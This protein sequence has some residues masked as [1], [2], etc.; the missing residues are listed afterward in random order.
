LGWE[1]PAADPLRFP[2]AAGA[3]GGRALA[4]RLRRGNVEGEYADPDYVVLMFTPENPEED[5]A[6]VLHA[7]RGGSETPVARPVPLFSPPRVAMGIRSALFAPHET[8]PVQEAA[9]R[10]CGAPTA[11]CPPAVPVVCCG[12]IIGEAEIRLLLHY[13]IEQM[14][15]VR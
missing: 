6:R 5:Y 8:L 4:D 3:E 12:E 2:L 15:V 14:E 7:L 11:S 1:F 10:I 13:G 9:G